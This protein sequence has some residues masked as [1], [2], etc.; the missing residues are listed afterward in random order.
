VG[1]APGSGSIENIQCVLLGRGS[2][3]VLFGG[4]ITLL[5]HVQFKRPFSGDKII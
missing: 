4:G 5:Y 1:I 3:V 2:S